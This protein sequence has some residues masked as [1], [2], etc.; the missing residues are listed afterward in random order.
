M[1]TKS[2]IE[3]KTCYGLNDLV[4]AVKVSNARD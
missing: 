1:L 3:L 2:R 4:D